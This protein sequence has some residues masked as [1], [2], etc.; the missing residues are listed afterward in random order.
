MYKKTKKENGFLL[1][2]DTELVVQLFSPIRFCNFFSF[3]YLKSGK[4]ITRLNIVQHFVRKCLN[5]VH[6]QITSAL[7]YE[8]FN[9]LQNRMKMSK[10]K[11]NNIESIEKK[12]AKDEEEIEDG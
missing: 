1:L 7:V 11:K 10:Q 3:V 9:P 8:Q 2:L 5:D 12:G 4:L 6:P